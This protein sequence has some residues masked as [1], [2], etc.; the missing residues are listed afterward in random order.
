VSEVQ[1]KRGVAYSRSMGFN[2]SLLFKLSEH[3]CN[4]SSSHRLVLCSF[5]ELPQLEIVGVRV[6][7]PVSHG[8]A[9]LVLKLD[10]L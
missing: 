7:V 1:S 3:G 9:A 2:S 5:R 8:V 6:K 10:T 4:S